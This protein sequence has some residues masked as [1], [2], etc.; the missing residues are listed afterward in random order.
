MFSKNH[1]HF[2]ILILQTFHAQRKKADTVYV[3]EKVIVYDTVYLEKALKIQP[4]GISIK[5]PPVWNTEIT[6]M[7]SYKDEV[8]GAE[9]KLSQ[10]FQFG[11]GIEAGIK[12]GFWSK[13]FSEKDSQSG[14]GAGIWLRNPFI[15]GFL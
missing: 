4:A 14:F 10:R 13:G 5:L 6:E 3:Y 1:F 9:A 15:K 11:A 12:K 2:F 8:K 7:S